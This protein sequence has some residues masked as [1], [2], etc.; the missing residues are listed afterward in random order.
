MHLVWFA[1]RSGGG[2]FLA[3]VEADG[4]TPVGPVQEVN[5]GSGYG[6]QAAAVLH[7][8]LPSG[9]DRSYVVEGPDAG[10]KGRHSC[11]CGPPRRER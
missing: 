8:G 5:G 6:S 3:V 10:G 11:S 9:P 1:I 4:T 2:D 7:F